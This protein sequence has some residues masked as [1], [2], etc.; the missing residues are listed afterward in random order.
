[1]STS[2]KKFNDILG[3]CATPEELGLRIRDLYQAATGGGEFDQV[4]MMTYH[5]YTGRIMAMLETDLGI[6]PECG[7]GLAGLAWDSLKK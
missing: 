7:M 6:G 2:L 3:E 4:S 5:Q 1:M